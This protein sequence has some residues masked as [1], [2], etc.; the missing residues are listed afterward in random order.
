MGAPLDM[1]ALVVR[2]R[3]H[4]RPHLVPLRAP[5]AR[6]GR[7]SPPP[8]RRTSPVARLDSPAP[9]AGHDVVHDDLGLVG[10]DV[11]EQQLARRVAGRPDVRPGRPKRLGQPRSPSSSSSTPAAPR[12]CPS[13]TGRR[14]VATRS[15]SARTVSAPPA[16][17]AIRRTR[18]CARSIVTPVRSA[19]PSFLERGHERRRGA[20][21]LGGQDVGERLEDRDLRPEPRVDLRELDADRA[22]ADHHERRGGGS[23]GFQMASLFVQYGPVSD[24]V[25]R[26]DRRFGSG[27]E[28]DAV[29]LD[30]RAV[31]ELDPMRTDQAG[32]LE[33]HA[34]SPRVRTER[35]LR[36]TARRSRRAPA[37]GRPAGRPPPTGSG[38]RTGRRPGRAMRSSRCAA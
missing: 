29:G 34:G 5:P 22:G 14:P 31:G 32:L 10:A 27:R 26:R 24:P 9:A 37:A 21:V 13:N 8:D 15:S 4:R 1:G 23:D 18:G 17:P 36:R 25:D 2:E 30:L 12:S 16:R 38:R 19:M 11:R 33:E 6:S 20:A 7:R 28:H 35:R 3:R